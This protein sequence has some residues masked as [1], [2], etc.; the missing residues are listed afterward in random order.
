MA[1][2]PRRGVPA[3][4]LTPAERA[5]ID[6][7]LGAAL[8]Q[9]SPARLRAAATR[10]RTLCAK[11]RDLLARQSRPGQR[12]DGRAAAEAKVRTREKADL[13]AGAVRR[14]EARL[15]ELEA[16]AGRV[17]TPRG[18]AAA[19]PRK[20]TPAPTAGFDATRQRSAKASAVK[21]RLAGAGKK[22]RS[23]HVLARGQRS[24]AGRDARGRR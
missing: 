1:K 10:A 2:S 24:Q 7:T 11:W 21:A 15:A 13:F 19:K 18:P 23:G 8:E 17:A 12:T 3:P 16:A 5:V 6:A 20:P 14:V 4:W 9:S 22:R